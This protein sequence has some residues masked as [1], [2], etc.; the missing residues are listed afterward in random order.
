M[1]IICAMKTDDGVWI[2]SDSRLSCGPFK[3]PSPQQKWFKTD[4]GIWWGY[5]GHSR[6]VEIAKMSVAINAAENASDLCEAFRSEVK[7]DAWCTDGQDPGDPTNYGF[8]AIIVDH[9]N[10]Y[11]MHGSGS[12][13]NFGDEF[14]ADGGGRE[15]AYGA[16]YALHGMDPETIMRVAIEAACRYDASCGGNIF[17]RK[18]P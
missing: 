4:A 17:V 12:L 18:L 5:N 2:G 9:G 1:T 15:Y 13:T 8:N 7:D 6:I 14:V 16:A 11:L 10:V 3:C